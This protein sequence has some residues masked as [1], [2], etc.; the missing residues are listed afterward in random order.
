[1]VTVAALAEEDCIALAI[2]TATGAIPADVLPLFFHLFGINEASTA[3]GHLGL[4]PAM[5]KRILFLW[6]GTV[7]A[8][9][10]E[11]GGVRITVRCPRASQFSEAQLSATVI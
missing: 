8:E 4:E 11:G 9:N 3:A 10:R 1:V 2:E 6:G 5:A 7:E